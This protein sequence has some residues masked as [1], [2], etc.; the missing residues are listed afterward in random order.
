MII[1]DGNSNILSA[2]FN[3]NDL[4]NI[5]YKNGLNET[6]V[7]VWSK[8]NIGNGETENHF[9]PKRGDFTCFDEDGNFYY[10]NNKGTTWEIRNSLKESVQEDLPGAKVKTDRQTASNNKLIVCADIYNLYYS[11]DRGNI[12]KS[13]NQPIHSVHIESVCFINGRFYACCGPSAVLLTSTDGINWNIVLQINATNSYFVEVRY[14]NNIYFLI[15][16]IITSYSLDGTSWNECVSSDGRLISQ[17]IIYN[18]ELYLAYNTQPNSIKTAIYKSLD[19]CQWEH[20][21][22]RIETLGSPSYIKV[23][24]DTNQYY[25]STSETLDGEYP[26]NIYIS[27]DGLQWEYYANAPDNKNSYIF[28]YD[29]TFYKLTYNGKF[30][31]STNLLSWTYISTIPCPDNSVE[32]HGF[33][34]L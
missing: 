2:E 10:S 18:G 17:H 6:N 26:Y 31:T 8:N 5:Y 21:G 3:S 19:G 12:W 7:L 28:Y 33:S 9:N 13:C 23:L 32:T 25:M 14:I 4:Q 20:S 22:K 29:N 34:I 1:K 30:Y 11:T 15:T 24:E 16:N 27:T